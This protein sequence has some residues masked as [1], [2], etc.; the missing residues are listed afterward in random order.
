VVGDTANDERGV[1]EEPPVARSPRFARDPATDG[2]G[3][4]ED[5]VAEEALRLPNRQGAGTA[6]VF[7]ARDARR[8]LPEPCRSG[9]IQGPLGGRC[10]LAERRDCGL[11]P[12]T[13]T[14]PARCS[15]MP[16][17]SPGRTRSNT[18]AARACA[19]GRLTVR[20]QVPVGILAPGR[21]EPDEPTLDDEAARSLREVQR[22]QKVRTRQAAD[23]DGE[24]NVDVVT[25]DRERLDRFGLRAC[26]RIPPTDSSR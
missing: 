24:L 15:A 7:L 18:S 16:G 13:A 8:A 9:P 25:E 10:G 22:A 6:I 12:R 26:L 1:C 4:A 3:L 2:E 14:A 20:A 21:G 17:R 5:A 11:D 19:R 23:L